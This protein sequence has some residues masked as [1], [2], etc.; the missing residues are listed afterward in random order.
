MKR[1]LIYIIGIGLL[2]AACDIE[3]SDNGDFDGLWQLYAVDTLPAGG[4]ADMR[5]SQIV[6]CVQGTLLELR[7]GSDV[8]KDYICNFE[9][10]EQMLKLSNPYLSKRDSGDIRVNDV[11]RLRL[12]GIN[13]LEEQFKV[14]QLTD[15]RMD[16]ESETL[17]LHFRKY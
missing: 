8:E 12:F 17:K 9:L 3:R 7:Q 10:T 14:L 6:W 2:M 16:L 15:S 13:Q 4:T 1:L 11:D 5:L